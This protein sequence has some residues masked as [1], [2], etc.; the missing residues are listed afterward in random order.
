MVLFLNSLL[1]SRR[2]AFC[3][4]EGTVLGLWGLSGVPSPCTP[5]GL[6]G[7]LSGVL[8]PPVERWCCEAGEAGIGSHCKAGAQSMR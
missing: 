5:P 6:C 4:L 2:V 1:K 7:L 8:Q 3:R